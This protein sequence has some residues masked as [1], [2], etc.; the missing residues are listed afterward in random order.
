M[1]S[2][3]RMWSVL[4]TEPPPQDTAPGSAL[5]LA[6]RSAVVWIGESTGT[7]TIS[8]SPT[9]RASGVT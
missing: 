9:I 8:N 6:T 7:T 2:P 3:A 4:P 1:I 5:S